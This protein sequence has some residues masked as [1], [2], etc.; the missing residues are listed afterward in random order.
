MTPQTKKVL[1]LIK[2]LV[3]TRAKEEKKAPESV[4][5][6]R[7]DIREHTG[8]TDYQLRKQIHELEEL[9]Y[10]IPVTGQNGKRFTY[11]LMWD[12]QDPDKGVNLS[13]VQEACDDLVTSL[14][15][16]CDDLVST[17]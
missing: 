9:E 4:V 13:D 3:D 11:V 12:G 16:P 7:R 5:I 1:P 10:L 15:P 8:W 17:L 14:R 6:S 2:D